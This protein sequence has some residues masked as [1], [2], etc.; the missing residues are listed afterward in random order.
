[1]GQGK[2]KG[3]GRRPLFKFS[4]V[5]DDTKHKQ[6]T[7]RTNRKKKHKKISRPGISSWVR[8]VSQ[9]LALTAILSTDTKVMD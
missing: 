7:S 2:G 9:A 6:R 8:A 4:L 5:E 3:T 1:M